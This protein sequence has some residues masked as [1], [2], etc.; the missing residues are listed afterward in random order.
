MAPSTTKATPSQRRVPSPLSKVSTHSSTAR[1]GKTSK[2]TLII[3]LKISSSRLSEVSHDSPSSDIDQVKDASPAAQLKIE[4][5]HSADSSS[6]TP[7]APTPKPASED[8]S[9]TAKTDA[10]VDPTALNPGVKREL[11][12]VV[13]GDPKSKARPGPK[14]KAKLYVALFI[15]GFV[16]S[17]LLTTDH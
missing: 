9:L 6:Q 2:P 14:K 4:S 7:D 5:K 8:D 11:G 17:L 13:K 10:K 15:L 12:S 1:S 16:M 3:R